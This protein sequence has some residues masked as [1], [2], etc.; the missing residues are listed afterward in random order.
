MWEAKENFAV[1]SFSKRRRGGERKKQ[2]R[3]FVIKWGEGEKWTIP[4][5]VRPLSSSHLQGRSFESPFVRTV[6]FFS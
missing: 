5:L 6:N 4:L 3:S 1:L 2:S